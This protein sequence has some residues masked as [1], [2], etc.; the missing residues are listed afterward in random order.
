MAAGRDGLGLDA[1]LV[2]FA[3]IAGNMSVTDFGEEGDLLA[4]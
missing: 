3:T 4:G 2:A 1:V